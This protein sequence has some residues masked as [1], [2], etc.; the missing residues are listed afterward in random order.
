VW[1]SSLRSRDH[2]RAAAVAGR[3]LGFWAIE[4]EREA[5]EGARAS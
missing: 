1:T 2:A 5:Q 3:G 4:G